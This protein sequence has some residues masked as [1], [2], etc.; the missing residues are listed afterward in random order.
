[1][2]AGDD[3]TVG[4]AQRKAESTRQQRAAP[5]ITSFTFIQSTRGSGWRQMGFVFDVSFSG[6][7]VFTYGSALVRVNVAGHLPLGNAIVTRW[8]RDRNGRFDGVLLAAH[9]QT[10]EA[11]GFKFGGT[12]PGN[13]ADVNPEVSHHFTFTGPASAR[14][15]AD[16]SLALQTLK[17][18]ASGLL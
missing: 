12:T 13:A 4:Q 16:S 18:A 1:M 3:I 7:P 9:V 17:Q 6:E 5:K 8:I 10:V 14:S 15:R 2:L 11:A